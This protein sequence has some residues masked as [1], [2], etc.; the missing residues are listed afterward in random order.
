MVQIFYL[1]NVNLFRT[2]QLTR[3]LFL[4]DAFYSH[5]LGW[6]LKRID[7]FSCF[8]LLKLQKDITY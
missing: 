4:A 8:N 3:F 6:C 7:I 2:Y 1:E 5:M